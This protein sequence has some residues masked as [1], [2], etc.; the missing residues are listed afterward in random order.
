MSKDVTIIGLS[1]L[2]QGDVINRLLK[3]GANVFIKKPF[4]LDELSKALDELL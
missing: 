2:D 1:T 3:A 4:Q